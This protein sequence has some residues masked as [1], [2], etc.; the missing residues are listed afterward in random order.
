MFVRACLLWF[1]SSAS[2]SNGG[3]GKI[4]RVGHFLL[5][6]FSSI[7]SHDAQN[8]H[9]VAVTEPKGPSRSQ[10]GCLEHNRSRV[11]L[12]PVCPTVAPFRPYHRPC[13][14]VKPSFWTPLTLIYQILGISPARLKIPHHRERSIDTNTITALSLR[15]N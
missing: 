10:V 5:T 11:I 8:T 14:R 7:L 2:R 3:S 13:R 15:P 1:W 12:L 9:G 4:G 6:A